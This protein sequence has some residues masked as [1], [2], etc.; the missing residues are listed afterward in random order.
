MERVAY[1]SEKDMAFS[2]REIFE[3]QN[4][5][6]NNIQRF[7]EEQ[8]VWV[9]RGLKWGYFTMRDVI[10]SRPWI[11]RV[12]S[13]IDTAVH[14]MGHV[15]ILRG[16]GQVVSATV[17][18]SSNYLGLTVGIPN[19]RERR[20]MSLVGGLAAEE[21]DGQDD[22]RGCGSDLLHL[23]YESKMYDLSKAE[24]ESR[25]RSEIGEQIIPLQREALGLAVKGTIAA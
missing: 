1:I 10:S 25:A 7:P 8:R 17:V 23:D 9:T 21:A 3:P 15:Y 6:E 24:A 2:S 20:L 12:L 18:P 19:S 14:E 5:V 4:E 13:V 22:H 16:G 11:E